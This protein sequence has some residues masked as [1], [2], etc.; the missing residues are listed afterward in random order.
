MVSGLQFRDIIRSGMMTVVQEKMVLPSNGPHLHNPYVS[1]SIP[2]ADY[3]NFLKTRGGIGGKF[4][5]PPEESV[6]NV[7]NEYELIK[8]EPHYKV[9]LFDESI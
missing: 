8:S 5:E 7:F 4:D 6:K 3:H 1:K 9:I 2:I